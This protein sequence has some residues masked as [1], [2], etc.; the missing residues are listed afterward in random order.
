MYYKYYFY[1]SIHYLNLCEL[2]WNQKNMRETSGIVVLGFVQNQRNPSEGRIFSDQKSW[3]W[4]KR[5]KYTLC[6]AHPFLHEIQWFSVILYSGGCSARTRFSL[7]IFSRGR[8]SAD[9]HKSCFFLK[10][11]NELFVF[12]FSFFVV[13]PYFCCVCFCFLLEHLKTKII[14]INVGVGPRMGP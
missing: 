6:S 12:L 2:N 13:P 3:P 5:K 10:L 14:I 9:L 4:A 1:P 7:K 11:F 8:C